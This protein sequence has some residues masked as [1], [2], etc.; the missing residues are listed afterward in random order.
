MG[1]TVSEC[2]LFFGVTIVMSC[3]NYSIIRM[4]WEMKWFAD[5]ITRDR[6]FA[7]R[8]GIKLVYDDDVSHE[9]RSKD[10][11]WKVNNKYLNVFFCCF[12]TGWTI[13]PS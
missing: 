3:V 8:N 9:D 11:L 4:Y 6:Y 1:L 12:R 7:I 5:A 10:K 13:K 2:K